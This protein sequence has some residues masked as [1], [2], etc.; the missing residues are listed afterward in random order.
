MHLLNGI[1][2]SNMKLS[3]H[4]HSHQRNALNVDCSFYCQ[5]AAHLP[6]LQLVSDVGHAHQVDVLPYGGLCAVAG[7][8]V[9]LLLIPAHACHLHMFP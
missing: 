1:C 2:L 3:E 8:K 6:V 5:L 9:A 4:A 7:G